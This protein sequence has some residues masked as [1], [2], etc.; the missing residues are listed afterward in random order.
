MMPILPFLTD[1]PQN[2]ERILSLAAESEVDY[3]LPGILF[4]RGETRKHFFNF[5]KLNFPELVDPYRKLYAKGG[6]DRAYKTELY[7]I[8]SSLME[9]YRLSGDYMKPMQA[10]FSRSK[11]LKLNDFYENSF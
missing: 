3:A 6:A 1:S 11:Q 7:G 8:L 2:I 10:N 5:L 9:K 4:L